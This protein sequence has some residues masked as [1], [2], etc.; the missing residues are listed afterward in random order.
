MQRPLAQANSFMWQVRFGQF[1]SS[2]AASAQ[3]FSLS[4]TKLSGTQR[5]EP[6]YQMG[7]VN[8]PELQVLDPKIY[9]IIVH[10]KNNTKI[11]SFN[12]GK[13]IVELFSSYIGNECQLLPHC[14]S[15]ASSLLSPQS[16]LPSHI[17]DV[18]MQCPFAQLN[19]CGLQVEA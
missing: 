17:K 12:Y 7:H 8:S 18:C 6:G 14:S 10:Q 15:G 19:C 1:C 11:H 9:K 16:L 5:G 13:G 3:S 2:S 4:H